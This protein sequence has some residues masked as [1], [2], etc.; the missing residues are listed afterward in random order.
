ML[1]KHINGIWYIFQLTLKILNSRLR[2]INF[3]VINDAFPTAD[4]FINDNTKCHFCYISKETSKHIFGQCQIINS[5]I[6]A[7]HNGILKEDNEINYEIFSKHI[8]LNTKQIITI[9]NIKFII[10]NTR[11]ILKYDRK[12][13]NIN[14][15]L[16]KRFLDFA[17]NDHG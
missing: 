15:F 17:D 3:K 1:K 6:N 12:I 14:K 7:T 11:N 2:S 8:F 4:K 13:L 16:E 10:W 9:S 5:S